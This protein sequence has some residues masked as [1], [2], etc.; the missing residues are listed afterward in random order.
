[1]GIDLDEDLPQFRAMLQPCIYLAQLRGIPLHYQFAN[2]THG[3][4]SQ[5]LESDWFDYQ[6]RAPTITKEAQPAKLHPKHEACARAVLSLKAMTPPAMATLDWMN[7]LAK[8]MQ[9]HNRQDPNPFNHNLWQRYPNVAQF[10]IPAL[11]EAGFITPEA[12][13]EPA[14]LADSLSQLAH[15]IERTEEESWPTPATDHIQRTEAL[16]RRM[17]TA[18]PHPYWVYP[19]PN[20][21]IVIDAGNDDLRVIVTL[22]HDRSVIYTYLNP[23]TKTLEVTQQPQADQ[24]PDDHMKHILSRLKNYKTP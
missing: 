18:E 12:T 24:L 22:H 16:L 23:D 20:R 7:V 14:P 9:L 21:E 5:R 13:P 2:T 8:S 1:M 19:T 10:I 3:F 6:S 17:F 15:T 4:Y 11:T